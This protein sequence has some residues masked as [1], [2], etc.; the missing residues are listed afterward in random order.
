VRP[1]ERS[2]P[3]GPMIAA[4]L[5][6]AT[7]TL[8]DDLQAIVLTSLRA[9]TTAVCRLVFGCRIAAGPQTLAWLAAQQSPRQKTGIISL[10]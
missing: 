4:V 5:P 6:M 8:M 9:S 2:E 1:T 3:T 10:R 7:A